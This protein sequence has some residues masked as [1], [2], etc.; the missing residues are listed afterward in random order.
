M[1]VALLALGT[2]CSQVLLAL[3]Q[4]L[5]GS[6]SG[7]GQALETAQRCGELDKLDVPLEEELAVGG[8]VVLNWVNTSGGL[9][10][11]LPPSPGAHPS[12]TTDRNRVTAYLDVVG[13]NLA[14]QSSRPTLPWTF[15]VLDSPG[16][17]AVSTPGGY[18]LVTRGLL[19]SVD[20]EVQL[21]GVLAHEIA[22]VAQRHGVSAYRKLKVDECHRTLAKD[23]V[24]PAANCF[25]QGISGGK[26]DLDHNPELLAVF[27]DGLFKFFQDQ[28]FDARLELEADQVGLELMMG[29]G[30]EPREYIQ[31]LGK[32]PA[33]GVAFPH[34]PAPA[35]RQ[36]ALQTW[37]AGVRKN[38]A[39]MHAL[40]AS[41]PS[42]VIPLTDELAAAR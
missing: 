12:L 31:F 10:L 38:D 33:T 5:G 21:A 39:F 30:Y 14:A 27:G 41:A 34:H 1:A 20:N 2:S 18:V 32:I 9:F 35:E 22:H 15:G 37:L 23:L 6:V 36:R 26:M 29:A 8:T 11:D 25:L 4:G 40:E 7:L 13:K 17:N 16:F 42:R 28:G 19:A 24:S 3:R